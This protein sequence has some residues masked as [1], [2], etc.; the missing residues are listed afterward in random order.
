MM[1]NK[2][3]RSLNDPRDVADAQ[4]LPVTESERDR[5][6]RRIGERAE[7]LRERRGLHV[8]DSVSSKFLGAP[9]VEAQEVAMVRSHDVIL[10]GVDVK[11]RLRRH[12]S[13]PPVAGLL[14]L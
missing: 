13:V 1:R 11:G 7:S 6:P 10:T 9:Q 5:Q 3:L 2:V 12:G 4:L 14:S 8:G